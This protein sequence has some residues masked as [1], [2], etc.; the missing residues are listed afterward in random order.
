M[1][2]IQQVLDVNTDI[3]TA[4]DYRPF[5]LIPAAFLKPT[6]TWFF[7]LYLKYMSIYQSVT[8]H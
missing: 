2:K 5:K 3:K 4:H 6:D 7:L 8:K 1:R